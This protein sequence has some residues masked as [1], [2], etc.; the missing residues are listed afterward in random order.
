MSAPRAPQDC[1][2]EACAIQSCLSRNNYNEAKC[3][4]YVD[5]LYKCCRDM[6]AAAQQ[7]GGQVPKST[8]CPIESV[9]NRRIKAMER[10]GR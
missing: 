1:Q 10:E 8:A 2:Q 6:Y 4:A 7:P 3:T 9:V 5:S